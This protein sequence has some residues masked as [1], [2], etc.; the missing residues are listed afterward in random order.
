M[1]NKEY[2]FGDISDQTRADFTRLMFLVEHG[3]LNH[4]EFRHSV[5]T[6]V[7]A[8]LSALREERRSPNG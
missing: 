1:S 8:Y 6:L 4:T 2:T 7:N 5:N 3:V